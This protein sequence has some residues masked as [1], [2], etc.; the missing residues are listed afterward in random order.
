MRYYSNADVTL[1]SEFMF[2]QQT[3]L[4]EWNPTYDDSGEY[5]ITFNVT[6]GELW[7]SETITITVLDVPVIRY[8]DNSDSEFNILSG[9]WNSRNL[10]NAYNNETRYNNQGVGLETA[11]WRV[12]NLIFPGR[13]DV[14]AWKFEHEYSSSMADNTHYMIYHRTGTT[15]WILVNQQSPGNEWVYL[16]NFEFDNSHAQGMKITDEGNGRI[17]ADAIKLFYT[18]PISN[19]ALSSG[20]DL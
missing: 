6:D 19:D 5:E 1:P 17:I 7:D 3:G 10:P 20:P 16:G 18:G 2:D 12:N 14:Y 9:E 13:Y 15:N 8:I 11:V 4:F